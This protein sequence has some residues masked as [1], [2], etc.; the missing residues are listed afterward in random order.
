MTGTDLGSPTAVW[1]GVWAQCPEGGQ[2]GGRL[3]REP[4]NIE[5]CRQ[6]M[7]SDMGLTCND[8]G[9]GSR[10]DI[11]GAGEAVWIDGDTEKDITCLPSP[12]ASPLFT[13]MTQSWGRLIPK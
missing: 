13:E 5:S 12:R 4:G 2:G 3:S 10:E 9:P 1:N 7:G 11:T 8:Q 6:E